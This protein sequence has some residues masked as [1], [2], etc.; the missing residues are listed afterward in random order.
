VCGGGRAAAYASFVMSQKAGTRSELFNRSLDEAEIEAALERSVAK[1]NRFDEEF[2]QSSPLARPLTASYAPVGV[3]AS[4]AA[5]ASSN[6]NGD[7]GKPWRVD[8]DGC[9][10]TTRSPTEGSTNDVSP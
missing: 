9:S 7:G 8:G 2:W 5:T 6:G 4:V 10:S 3:G 1:L